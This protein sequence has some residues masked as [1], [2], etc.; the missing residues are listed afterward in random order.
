MFI[1]DYA[2]LSFSHNKCFAQSL[3][4]KLKRHF[5]F[6]D[7]FENVPLWDN[8]WKCDIAREV[9]ENNVILGLLIQKG[10]QYMNI[11]FK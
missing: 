2:S 4:W 1:D 8:V 6:N 9:T 5:K 11:Y 7:I 3:Y 10:Q